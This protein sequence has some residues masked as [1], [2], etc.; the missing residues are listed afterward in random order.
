MDGSNDGSTGCAL[1]QGPGNPR[2]A[3]TMGSYVDAY[4]GSQEEPAFYRGWLENK[5]IQYSAAYRGLTGRRFVPDDRVFDVTA[6]PE[7]TPRRR[8]IVPTTVGQSREMLEF[9]LRGERGILSLFP[10]A[11]YILSTQPSANQFSGDFPDVY[12]YP[13]LSEERRAAIAKRTA[14]LEQYLAQY[15]SERC[16]PRTAQPSMAYIFGNGAVQLEAMVAEAR[17]HGHDARYFNVGLL[18]PDAMDD[19]IPYFID[20][21]H[22]SGR[23]LDVVGKFYNESSKR[24][25]RTRKLGKISYSCDGIANLRGDVLHRQTPSSRRA[26]S[27]GGGSALNFLTTAGGRAAQAGEPLQALQRDW[28]VQETRTKAHTAYGVTIPELISRR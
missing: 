13:A 28:I 3:A 4:L 15:E 12:K 20:P 10:H 5:I 24:T 14:A 2:F 27:V 18:F 21:V 7:G 26:T 22:L 1:S 6:G 11:R 23:G 8:Q 16:G 17:A 19:R 9:Y 25:R